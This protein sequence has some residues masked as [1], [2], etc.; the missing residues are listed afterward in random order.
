MEGFRAYLY[1]RYTR[2][3]ARIRFSHF[4][5][6]YS[7]VR[8]NPVAIAWLKPSQARHLLNALAAFRD[9]CS[10]MGIGFDLDLRQLRKLAPRSSSVRVMEYEEDDKIVEQAVRMVQR[11]QAGTVYRL[12]ALAGFYTGL[13]TPEIVHM[14]NN[15]ARLRRIEHQGAAIV[16]LGYE[17]R[18][19]KAWVTIMP[20]QLAR[21]IDEARPR[22]GDTAPQTLRD[23]YGVSWSILRKAHLAILASKLNPLEIELL[24]GRVGRITVKHYVRHLR[25][26]AEKYMEAYKPH[27]HLLAQQRQGT[28]NQEQEVLTP[29]GQPNPPAPTTDNLLKKSLPQ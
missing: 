23:E 22:V 9:Y 13:R 29:T 6:F 10:L 15:W 11:I 14:I 18:T 1:S 3:D 7:L 19:K 4:R 8:E 21:M 5:R 16:E 17:R 12:L 2:E 26:I 25:E 27:L 24:Q 20:L 28:P